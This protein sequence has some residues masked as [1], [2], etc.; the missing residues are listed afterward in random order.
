MSQKKRA[1]GKGLEAL[2]P[3]KNKPTEKKTS[4]KPAAG[5]P[6]VAVEPTLTA[7][8]AAPNL[9]P[10]DRIKRNE[11]QPRLHFDDD[12]LR[13]LAD[14]IKRHG[15]IQPVAVMPRGEDYVLVAGERRWRAAQLAGLAE[16]PALVLDPLS[17]QELLEF[18][19]VENLQREDLS[20]LDEAKAYA[21]LQANFGLT[22]DEIAERV[23]K[24]RPA[25]ANALRLLT[26]QPVMQQDLESGLITPGHARAILSLE[27]KRDQVRLR[28]AIVQDHYSVRQAEIKARE[29]IEG[30]AA[31]KG[32][33][34][35]TREAALSPVL[36]SARE[37]MT[38]IFRCKVR[39]VGEA[40]DK[41]KI[42]ISY[43]SIDEFQ[44]IVD[45]LKLE[46]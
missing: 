11:A 29:M 13:D 9:L 21:S 38:D 5:E 40:E 12:T 20:P 35:T 4:E 43:S 3:R 36:S 34:R 24:S 16:V 10:I 32:V 37:Q 8:S 27:N 18:A 44:H 14:S 41:G 30:G 23:G 42:E 6:E 15:L 45:V 26:L 28:D 22:G 33:A 25:I 31:R 17:D 39:I 46:L 19:L 7:D 2:L 1:L